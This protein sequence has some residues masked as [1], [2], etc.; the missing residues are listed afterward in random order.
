MSS[1]LI[2]SESTNSLLATLLKGRQGADRRWTLD[3]D[4]D[5]HRPHLRRHGQRAGF[6]ERR[7]L[8]APRRPRPRLHERDDDQDEHRVD[9]SILIEVEVILLI[10]IK[11]ESYFYTIYG[12]KYITPLIRS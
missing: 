2:E 11:F 5:C 6:A 9:K 7:R 4:R 12:A 1:R 3:E 10:Q 8:E